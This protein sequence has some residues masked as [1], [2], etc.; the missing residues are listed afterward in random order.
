MDGSGHVLACH[1]NGN[2]PHTIGLFRTNTVRGFAMRVF[3]SETAPL[4]F[5]SNLRVSDAVGE[6]SLSRLPQTHDSSSTSFCWLCVSVCP[7]S[8]SPAVCLG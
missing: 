5:S 8:C 6:N 2:S 1:H 7:L 3:I 4:F